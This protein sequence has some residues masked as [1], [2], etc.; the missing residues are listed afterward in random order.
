[1]KVESQV[2]MNY[3]LELLIKQRDILERVLKLIHRVM[4]VREVLDQLH[5][6]LELVQDHREEGALLI[7]QVHLHIV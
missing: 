2:Q 1:M 4:K 5:Q 6:D 7:Q 3:L